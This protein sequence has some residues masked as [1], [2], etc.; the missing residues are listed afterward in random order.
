MKGLER[1][2]DARE[3]SGMNKQM[4]QTI[5]RLLGCCLAAFL[6]VIQAYG[7]TPTRS[8][9]YLRDVIALSETLGKSHSIRILCNGRNDQHW[10]G[11]MQ[12][13]LDLEAPYQGGLRRSMVDGFNAGYANTNADH[14]IC[15]AD[16]LAAEQQFAAEGQALTRKL[17][18][19][20]IPGQPRR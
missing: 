9:D 13:L 17:A 8:Q 7:Q 16:T 6:P 14:S 18:T 4:S 15:D 2:F 1:S 3:R 5:L 20:N 19:E 12:R 10:R 11:Y